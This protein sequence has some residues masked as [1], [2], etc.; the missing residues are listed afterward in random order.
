VRVALPLQT[1]RLIVRAFTPADRPA[2]Q[3]M[4]ADPLVMLHIDTRGEDPSR[5]VDAYIVHQRDHGYG[6]WALQERATGQLIGEAGLAPFDGV[7]PWLELGYLLRRD[8]WGQGLATEAARACLDAAF[9]ALGVPEVRAV[10]DVG[11][12]GS[13]NVARKLG[14]REIGRRR[15]GGRRQHVLAA[16]RPPVAPASAVGRRFLRSR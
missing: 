2:M 7:G 5:W 15:R 6:F 12:D 14:F 9:D 1:D 11:N 13:L 10:I 16:Q 8:R 4:Y 3:A